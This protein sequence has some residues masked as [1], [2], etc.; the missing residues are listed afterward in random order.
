[1]IVTEGSEDGGIYVQATFRTF[2]FEIA[3]LC[4]KAERKK[5]E[6][7][8]INSKI[9][10]TIKSF[11]NADY[12]ETDGTDINNI[13]YQYLMYVDS[14]LDILNPIDMQKF[15][16]F[17]RHYV[18]RLTDEIYDVKYNFL[19]NRY[20]ERWGYALYSRLVFSVH[21]ENRIAKTAPYIR[22][23]GRNTFLV[24]DK[25][26]RYS[27][28]GVDD[29]YPYKFDR[30]RSD[31]LHD[32]D[33]YRVFFPNKTKDGKPIIDSDT[34]FIKLVIQDL[35]DVTQREFIWYLPL[36]YPIVQRDKLPRDSR[37]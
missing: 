20:D 19:R 27:P 33:D 21:L 3:S 22:W 6:R 17:K 32:T 1:M 28:S 25:G 16:N 9:S 14:S 26:N 34:K 29:P 37:E 36:S 18:D 35:G 10:Q 13:Y 12:P 11:I 15:F 4:R 7:S 31:R 23:I 2:A 24:D 30:P 5:W 8:E